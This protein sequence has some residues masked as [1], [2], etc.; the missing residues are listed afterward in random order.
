MRLASAALVLGL[1]AVGCGGPPPAPPLD[2][3]S[4]AYRAGEPA[5][6]LDAVSAVRGDTSGIDIFLGLPASSLVFRQRQEGRSAVARWTITVEREGGAPVIRTPL[7]TLEARSGERPDD[8]WRVERVDVPPG[9]YLVRAVLEDRTSERTAERTMRVEVPLPDGLTALGG[10]R[11]ERARDRRPIDPGQVPAGA[12]SLRVVVQAVQ[13]PDGATTILT[14]HRVRAEDEPARPINGFTPTEGSLI[15]RG[16]DTGDVELVQT[17]RQPI[18]N[19]DATLDVVAPLPPLAAGVYNARLQ[20]VDGTGADLGTTERLFVVR[21]TDYPEV[22]RRGDLI[23]PIAYL[24]S[25]REYREIAQATTPA[26]RRRAFDRFW[27]ERMDD[28]RLASATVRSYFE[29]VEEANRLFGTYKE[30]WKTDPGMAYI[31]FGPP[32]FVERTVRGERWTYAS[33]GATPPVLEFQQTAGGVVSQSPFT[34]LILNR[35]RG[36]TDVWQR[37]RRLWRTGVIPG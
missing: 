3:R 25:E 37:A 14:V 32:R 35:D 17:V 19:P 4:V 33:T 27:G 16:I 30:G 18:T 20:L 6:V 15:A 13:V 9:A 1:L 26:A 34:V 12:D 31:L 29:R 23:G 11:L 10:L 28:A 22:T 21:R 5:F 8:V 36:Y 2:G 7:D 24:A